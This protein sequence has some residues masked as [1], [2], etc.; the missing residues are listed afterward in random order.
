MS[1]IPDDSAAKVAI[2]IACG[3]MQTSQWWSPVIAMLL[4]EQLRG[5]EITKVITMSSALPDLN[6]NTFLE[7]QKGRLSLTDANRVEIA[8]G[9]LDTDADWLFQM[10][11]DT[12]PPYD[13]ITRLLKAKRD[14]I[15]GLYFLPKPPYNPIAYYRQDNGLYFP[16]YNYPK[17]QLTQVDSIGMGCTLIHRSVFEKIRD[18]HEVFVRP[19]GSLLAVLKDK[20]LDH[21]KQYEKQKEYIANGVYHLPVIP[22][23]PEDSRTFPYYAMEYGRTEDHHFCELA[24]AVGIKP[25]LD[26]TIVCEHWKMQKVTV[27]DYDREIAKE[28]GL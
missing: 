8:T 22:T 2:G 16:V 24:A 14:F 27:E 7:T 25:W 5:I 17:G 3:G 12:V 1:H 10:D 26:T 20:V 21:K 28:A 18:A 9:F 4:Q 19:N 23:D 15:G 6:K 11:D 13:V